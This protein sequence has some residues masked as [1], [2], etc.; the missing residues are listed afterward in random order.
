MTR[1]QRAARRDGANLKKTLRSQARRLK[2]AEQAIIPA[3]RRRLR[4]ACVPIQRR[5]SPLLGRIPLATTFGRLQAGVVPCTAIETALARQLGDLDSE[6]QAKLSALLRLV[7]RCRLHDLASTAGVAWLSELTVEPWV[8]TLDEF[9]P[10]GKSPAARRRALIRRLLQRYPTPPCLVWE[11]ADLLH[12]DRYDNPRF[13]ARVE[14]LAR[15]GRGESMRSVTGLLPGVLTRRMHHQLRSTAAPTL[16]VAIRRIQVQTLGG[17]PRLGIEVAASLLRG[18]QPHESFWLSVIQWLCQQPRLDLEQVR[19][20]LDY[21]GSR[22][23]RSPPGMRPPRTFERQWRMPDPSKVWSIKGRTVPA[24]LR[25]MEAWHASLHRPSPITDS[26]EPQ[27]YAPSGFQHVRFLVG[28]SVWR[29]TEVL[30]R[31][32]LFAEGRA[33]Q[34]CVFSYRDQII[35]GH[36]SIWSMTRDGDQILTVEVTNTRKRIVQARGVNNRS[37]TTQERDILTEWA[38]KAGLKLA[39]SSML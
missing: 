31:Q 33:M 13:S 35:E 1:K 6:Q 5:G 8:G 38:Q 26:E 18:E 12:R 23:L 34:H 25:D 21:I 3:P 24:L 10:R 29:M 39:A 16:M 20:M 14:L 32:E 2:R 15:L 27:V 28:K 4:R 19:P 36:T 11:L 9:K 17:S 37:P 7:D 30:T 22:H